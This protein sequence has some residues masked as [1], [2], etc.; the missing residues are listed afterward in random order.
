MTLFDHPAS[1]TSG[2]FWHTIRCHAPLLQGGSIALRLSRLPS[3]LARIAFIPAQK[4]GGQW[5]AACSRF[6]NIFPAWIAQGGRNQRLNTLPQRIGDF[7]RWRDLFSFHI[8]CIGEEDDFCQSLFRDILLLNF[9]HVGIA[10]ILPTLYA[11]T[12]LAIPESARKLFNAMCNLMNIK[13]TPCMG[14]Y[15]AQP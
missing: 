10:G 12:M 3:G 4:L 14:F 9:L 6:A 2:R 13:L 11:S 15:T 1:P 7:P 8:G 5:R